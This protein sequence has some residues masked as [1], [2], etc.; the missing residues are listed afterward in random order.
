MWKER[1][2]Q[3]FLVVILGFV[4]TMC[5][6]SA[7]NN[8]SLNTDGTNTVTVSSLPSVT[9]SNAGLSAIS[10]TMMSIYASYS[11]CTITYS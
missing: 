5:N 7:S 10:Y 1:L 3:V 4:L 2:W 9:L 11:S 8:K 6:R